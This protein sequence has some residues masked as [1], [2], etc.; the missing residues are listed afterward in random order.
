MNFDEYEQKLERLYSEFAG[1]VKFILEQAIAASSGPRPQSIQCRAKDATH[2]KPK[3]EK[4]GLLDSDAIEREIKDLAGARVIFYTNTDVDRFLNARLIPENFDVDWGETRIH[5][6]TDENDQIQ[7]RAVHY[8]VSLGEHRTA[9]PE[10]ERFAGLRCEIQIQTVLIHAWAETSH[11]MLYKAPVTDGFG[12]KAL[13]A[14]RKRMTRVMEKFLVP[15]G[16]ELQKVQHDFERFLQ[17]KELFDRGTIEALEE[18]TNN[19]DRHEIL[20]KIQE[21]VLPNYDAIDAIYPEVMRVLIKTVLAARVTETAPIVTAF[22]DLPGKTA[23]DIATVAVAILEGLRYV[24][25]EGTFQTLSE[26]Y[27]KEPDAE[28]RKRI[29]TAIKHLSEYN[30]AALE[31]V[32][33]Q[34]Q[35]VLTDMA[36]R[37]TASERELRKPLL[38]TLWSEVLS[39][40]VTGTAWAADSVTIRTGAVHPDEHLKK[41]R[42]LAIAGLLD[43]FD[44][45]QSL[46][47]RRSILSYL[48]GATRLPY[49]ANYPDALTR[50]VTEDT[51]R[52]VE[53]LN[54]R[55]SSQSYELL[56]HVEHSFLF[57]YQRAKQIVDAE[58][59]RFGEKETSARLA[60]AVISFREVVNSDP[61]FVRYKTLVGFE[62]VFP[63]QWDDSTIYMVPDEERLATGD[64]YIAAIAADN[65]EEW[66]GF[67]EICADSDSED[68]A[69]FPVFGEFLAR[70]AKAK[71]AVALRLIARASVPLLNFMP[72]FLNGLSESEAV[73][74]YQDLLTR[75]ID[76]GKHLVAVARHI[77]KAA[78]PPTDTVKRVLDKAIPV[79]DDI[80][81]IEC[82]VV[83]VQHFAPENPRLTE[84]VFVPAIEFLSAKKDARWVRGAYFL[85]PAKAFFTGLT[86]SQAGLVLDNLVHLREIRHEAEMILAYLAENHLEA[87]WNYFGRRLDTKLDDD[88]RYEAVPYRFHGLEKV[89]SKDADLAVR[90]ALSWYRQGDALFRFHGGRLVSA[91]FPTVPEPYANALIALAGDGPDDTVRFILAILE[92]YQGDPVIHGILKSLVNRLPEGDVR[93]SSLEV[94]LDNTGVV[95][96]EFGF[97]DAYRKKKELLAAWLDDERPKVRQFAAVH[98]QKLDQRIASEQRSAEQRNELRKRDYEDGEDDD[99]PAQ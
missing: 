17:G 2:L 90:T 41:V 8:T 81:V 96:G 84:E 45:S 64:E 44:K 86:A 98:I 63:E 31:Q 46:S 91:A 53:A 59:D 6:P 60:A 72:A 30:L 92:N 99:A 49:Q 28:V 73:A 80:A 56:E 32:G 78:L 57:Y 7:Y 3:L 36:A 66:F 10:Y 14:I 38:Q 18:C 83:A 67:L 58:D 39:P 95:S 21:Y 88:E 50:L 65:E 16:Y 70:L 13:L 77:R 79:A 43:L 89:L 4:R 26:I 74:E 47:Q 54:A 71:P 55:A 27:F 51:I 40:E 93:L 94:A 97:V 34:I 75:C 76:D 15:A 20:T 62:G 82:V 35:V 29:L 42:S 19:N 1:T 5:H 69:T 61:L 48:S 23:S 52:I 33:I 11:D 12:E 25:A 68:L 22:G 85:T 37:L 24:D 87:V 9:L